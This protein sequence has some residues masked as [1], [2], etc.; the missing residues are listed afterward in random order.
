MCS[1]TDPYILTTPAVRLIEGDLNGAIQ[2]GPAYI[3][4]VCW[5][6]EFRRNFIKLKEPNRSIKLTFIMN[7]LLV[8]QIGYVKVVTILCPQKMP[9]QEHLN[10]MK[11]CPIFSKL[12]RLCPTELNL[13]SQ[14]IQFMFIVAK[15]KVPSKD[16]VF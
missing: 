5:K 9:M 12:D 1:I 15:R 8:N 16:K 11:L 3:C 13:I 14:T 7:A 6:F 10:D 2:E 4:D